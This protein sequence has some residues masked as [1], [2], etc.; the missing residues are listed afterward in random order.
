MRE[1]KKID[2]MKREELINKLAKFPHIQNKMWM[3]GNIECRQYLTGLKLT[4]RPNR[5]GF[6][7]EIALAIDD[8]IELHD[9]EYPQFV[10][11]ETIWDNNFRK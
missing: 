3:W 2:K 7:F 1:L 5:Q 10:P 8:L 6:P 9:L 4:D 11:A